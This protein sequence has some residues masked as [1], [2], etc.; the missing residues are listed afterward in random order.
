[1]FLDIVPAV[2]DPSINMLSVFANQSFMCARSVTVHISLMCAQPLFHIGTWQCAKNTH[3][4]STNYT[5][6]YTGLIP[7]GDPDIDDMHTFAQIRT[8]AVCF[9]LQGIN[10]IDWA[11]L[12]ST[13]RTALVPTDEEEKRRRS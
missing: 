8:L 12:Q 4:H 6:P 9:S 11:D 3:T 1:M 7:L 10:P 5:F 2:N 13:L